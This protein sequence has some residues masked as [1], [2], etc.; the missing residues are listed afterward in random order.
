M[1]VTYIYVYKL[2][3]GCYY[4]GRTTRPHRRYNQHETGKGS[5]WTRLHGGAVLVECIPKTVKDEDEADAAENI[6]TLQ[7]MQRYGWQKVRG[8]WFC[9]V[10]EVQTEKNLRHHGVF[11]LVAFPPPNPRI[12]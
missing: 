1:L 3:N 5:A 7:L 6:K 4:V 10:D 8:G 9:G 2:N 11:D 12:R